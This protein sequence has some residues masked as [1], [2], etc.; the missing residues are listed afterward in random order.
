MLLTPDTIGSGGTGANSGTQPMKVASGV[1]SASIPTAISGATVVPDY[2]VVSSV[3]PTYDLVADGGADPAGGTAAGSCGTG[4]YGQTLDKTD[5]AMLAANTYFASATGGTVTGCGIFNTTQPWIIV[6]TGISR[7][8]NSCGSGGFFES[9]VGNYGSFQLEGGVSEPIPTPTAAPTLSPATSGGSLAATTYYVCN[10]LVNAQ[11]ETPCSPVATEVVGG[12]GAGSIT[13]SEMQYQP[14]GFGGNIY[15]STDATGLGCS[16]PTYTNC[17]LQPQGN[18]VSGGS[19]N[20]VLTGPPFFGYGPG[21][22]VLKTY[23]N[24]GTNPPTTNGS[25]K[26]NSLMQI[27]TTATGG[28]NGLVIDG[29]SMHDS[30]ASHNTLGA[31]LVLVQDNH[32]QVLHS[33]FNQCESTGSFLTSAPGSLPYEQGCVAVAFLNAGNANASSNYNDIKDSNFSYNTSWL[34]ASCIRHHGLWRQF[35]GSHH[36]R[37]S[38]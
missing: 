30:S 10:T 24:S 11:G 27:G 31:M 22:I 3:S 4:I 29:I 35:P 5:C 13:F 34:L 1:V 23:T 38:H 28:P 37:I 21:N 2:G 36:G 26:A 32:V 8:I 16:G 20:A 6:S 7:I 12:S 14:G 9:G 33:E 17:F 25:S 18:Y 15:V 19:G